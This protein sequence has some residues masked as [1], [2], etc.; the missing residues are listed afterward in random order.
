VLDGFTISGGNSP[1]GGGGVR[2]YGN[3]RL[4]NLLFLSNHSAGEGGGLWL[5]PVS[6]PG[7]NPV[8]SDC[9]FLQNSAERC[10][11]A[12]TYWTGFF[13]EQL[14]LTNCQFIQNETRIES[15]CTE[16]YPKYNGGGALNVSGGLIDVENCVFSL[17][18]SAW[19]GGGILLQAP[20]TARISRS[21]FFDNTAHW[22]GQDCARRHR[23]FR[24]TPTLW[25][26]WFK[27]RFGVTPLQI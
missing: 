11:G 23:G 17:N 4:Q 19:F 10:G 24:P 5:W 18:S 15:P 13:G 20:A 1:S 25:P 27:A 12:M 2:S 7:E 21:E 8:V 6:S 22:G 3:A 26:K 9:L 14:I 16:P